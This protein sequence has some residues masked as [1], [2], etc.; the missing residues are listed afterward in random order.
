LA[1]TGSPEK[2]DEKVFETLFRQHFYALVSFSSHLIFDTDAA[3]DIVHN[4]FINLWENRNNIHLES[5]L[6]SWLFTSVRNRS[7]NYLRDNKKFI[8]NSKEIET[9][10]GPDTGYDENQASS[11]ELEGR[12]RAALDRLPEACRRIFIMIRFDGLKYR[13]TA[14]KLGISQKT[15]ETQMSRAFK[16]LREELKDIVKILLIIFILWNLM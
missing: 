11:A 7:L 4:V 16:I 2:I 5:S 12:V 10:A 14:E 8:R 13:E 9:G 6:R 3:K 15:I 1:D